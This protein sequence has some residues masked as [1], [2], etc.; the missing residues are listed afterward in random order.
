MARLQQSTGRKS[1]AEQTFRRLAGFEG[2]RTI[3]GTYLFQ[4]GR[5]DEAVR[6]F[7][8]VVRENPGDRTA[9]TSLLATYQAL[10]RSADI[11]R[12]L[13]EALKKNPNDSDALLKRAEVFSSRGDYDK[14]EADLNT[15]VKAEPNMP[16]AHY[17]RA[18][19]YKL[20]GSSRMYRQDLSE[21][22]RLN[23]TLLPVRIELAQDLVASRDGQ[24]ALDTLDAAPAAQKSALTLLVARN[25]ALW[26]KGDMPEMR[27]GI[28]QVLAL[29]RTPDVLIQDGMWKSRAGNP[30]AALKSLREALNMDPG[31]LMAM[32]VLNSIYVS[33]KNPAEALSEVKMYAAR[34][35]K[36]VPVQNF[37]AQ[38]LLGRGETAQARAVLLAAKAA[39]PGATE[40]EL[41]L[42]Q[43]D[44]F[45][46]KYDDATT[47]L[48]AV[49]AANPKQPTALLWLGY[50]EMK[51]GNHPAAIDQFRKVLEVNPDDAQAGNDLA[52]EMAEHTSDL[53]G[54]LKYAQH[55]VEIAPN[56]AAF[57]DTL[58]WILYRKGLY[59]SAL[60]YLEQAN[61]NP[62]D[63][64]AK[65]HLAMAYAK[66][67]NHSQ[68]VAT[69]QVALK[70]DPNL[71]EARAARDLVGTSR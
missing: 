50:I 46:T 27:K 28:D 18:H 49:L 7:E 10:N 40:L 37:L 34:V 19:V 21:T 41:S 54:A 17:L 55:A 4:D 67:G 65:Y 36:S 3:Y 30:T 64:V 45:E 70:L 20:R 32:Q 66:M 59:P 6:E 51:R 9:R 60:P 63:V 13:A 71:P 56:Q 33:Q 29:Q 53:D 24:T 15:V 43:A 68:S 22:L 35:P 42:I 23:P 16:E 69:L 62:N 2:Y 25:W 47:K 14:A 58:G 52:Y 31:N 1:D 8:R 38:M 5:R 44:Y 61:T 26:A 57:A 48:N 11:D 39:A 12:V